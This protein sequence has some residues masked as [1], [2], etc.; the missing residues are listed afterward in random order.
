E[1]PGIKLNSSKT[2]VHGELY[3]ITN[4]PFIWKC[5]DRFEL[6]RPLF[7]SGRHEYTRQK[8][9]IKFANRLLSAW[10]YQYDLP[11]SALKKIKSGKYQPNNSLLN[12]K[13]QKQK[14]KVLNE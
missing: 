1:Y 10:V 4:K 9:I 8:V 14:N 12:G 13:H 11:V 3:K 6:S 5:L 7:T 2:T